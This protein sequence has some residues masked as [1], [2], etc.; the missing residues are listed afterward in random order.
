MISATFKIELTL[1]P[2]KTLPPHS[3]CS[4]TKNDSVLQPGG[5]ASSVEDVDVV[6]VRSTVG[7]PERRIFHVVQRVRLSFAQKIRSYRT[8]NRA[9]L[10][11]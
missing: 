6:R 9:Y 5:Q 4:D 10:M 2:H 8:A 7:M 1:P 3:L 11:Q